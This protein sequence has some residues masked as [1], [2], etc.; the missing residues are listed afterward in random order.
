MGLHG[1]RVL[2]SVRGVGKFSAAS[3]AGIPLQVGDLIDIAPLGGPRVPGGRTRAQ[4]V[5]LVRRGTQPSQRDQGA[6]LAD[7]WPETVTPALVPGV[8]DPAHRVVDAGA[9]YGDCGGQSAG[10]R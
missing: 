1:G 8:D 2:I 3:R 9:S 7:V 4:L 5:R 6:S 10:R